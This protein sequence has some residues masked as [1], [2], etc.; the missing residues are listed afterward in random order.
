[1]K[2]FHDDLTTNEAVE[3]SFLYRSTN[4][5]PAIT[6]YRK[7]SKSNDRKTVGI[8]DKTRQRKGLWDMPQRIVGNI[9]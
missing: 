6:D 2:D 1:M 3:R 7:S 4:N 8:S 9:K 5:L